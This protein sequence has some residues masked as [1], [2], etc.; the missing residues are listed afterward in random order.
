MIETWVDPLTAVKILEKTW[1]QSVSGFVMA[2][3]LVM[4]SA[5][6]MHKNKRTIRKEQ[7]E[8]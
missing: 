6:V 8:N 2:N 3:S 1:L 5:V 4:A 7:T